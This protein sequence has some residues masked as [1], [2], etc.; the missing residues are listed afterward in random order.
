MVQADSCLSACERGV[1]RYVARI[2]RKLTAIISYAPVV[3]KY[4]VFFVLRGTKR[5]K[6]RILYVGLLLF[7]LFVLLSVTEVTQC[8]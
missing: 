2:R 3:R 8:R 5:E 4:P 1:C 7:A 6:E